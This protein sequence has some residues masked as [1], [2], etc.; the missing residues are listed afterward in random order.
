MKRSEFK[1]VTKELDPQKVYGFIYGS[2]GVRVQDIM[3][4]FLAHRSS[5]MDAIHTL[6][7]DK[8]IKRKTWRYYA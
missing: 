8:K 5:V 3:D 1:Y 6:H 7:R 4:K 2:D